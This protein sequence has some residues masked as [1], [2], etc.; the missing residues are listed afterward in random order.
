MFVDCLVQSG[1]NPAIMMIKELVETEQITGTKASWALGTLSYYAKTPTQE[2]LRELVVRLLTND[3]FHINTIQVDLIENFNFLLIQSDR[4]CGN[5][6]PF[7]DPM[8]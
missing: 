3:R 4:T 8:T 7:R 6:A 2:L 1:S 5:L